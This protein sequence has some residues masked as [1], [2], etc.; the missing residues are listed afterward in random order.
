MLTTAQFHTIA[1][2]HAYGSLQ[3]V[4]HSYLH[5]SKSCQPLNIHS[6]VCLLLLHCAILLNI[7]QAIR[8]YRTSTTLLDVTNGKLD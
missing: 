4:E 7:S 5:L 6:A 1:G 8:Y 3:N 2:V